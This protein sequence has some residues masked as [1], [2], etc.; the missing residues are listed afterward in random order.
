MTQYVNFEE[1]PNGNLKI[2][3]V[4]PEKRGEYIEDMSGYTDPS[5]HTRFSELIGDQLCNGWWW[6][7]AADVGALTSDYESTIL[8][9]EV[10]DDE[11]GDITNVGR[12][13][14]YP[15]YEV[16]DQIEQ[17]MKNGF[18]IFTGEGEHLSYE[19]QDSEGEAEGES[20]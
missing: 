11:R 2:S 16:F 19:E 18:V 10:E 20:Q 14:W 7:C 1:L 13:Y 3:W 15:Q 4:S 8:S 6:L 5:W 9:Q 12:V 17:L